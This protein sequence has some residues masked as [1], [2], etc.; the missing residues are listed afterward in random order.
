MTEAMS[1]AMQSSNQ[2]PPG[3]KHWLWKSGQRLE[4]DAARVRGFFAFLGE[5][6]GLAVAR[7]PEE[8]AGVANS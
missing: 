1:K 4:Q 6:T 5:V 3:K 7:A 2:M 8:A